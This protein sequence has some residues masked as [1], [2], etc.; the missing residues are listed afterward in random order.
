MKQISHIS[1]IFIAALIFVETIGVQIIRDICLPCNGEYVAIQV[2]YSDYDTDC[3]DAC[4][5]YTIC[6]SP[7]N[8]IECEHHDQHSHENHNHKKEVEVFSNNPEFIKFENGLKIKFI[9][10]LLSVF[11]H[12]LNFCL[13]KNFVTGYTFN[14]LKINLP[15]NNLQELLCTYLI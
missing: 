15:G 1:A 12:Q 2:P 5:A 3:E 7:S 8:K 4:Q 9:P 14:K 10:I 13:S 11:D 6:K